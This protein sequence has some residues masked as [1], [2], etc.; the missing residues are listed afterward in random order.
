MKIAIRSGEVLHAQL[1]SRV[2][3]LAPYSDQKL[4]ESQLPRTRAPLAYFTETQIGM[5]F[6]RWRYRYLKK[7]YVLTT[8]RFSQD[9]SLIDEQ[10]PPALANL[11]NCKHLAFSTP[12]FR[13]FCSVLNVAPRGL[14]AFST[15]D[16]HIERSTFDDVDSSNLFHFR[17]LHSAD[18]PPNV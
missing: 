10:L 17:V 6:N 3:R 14:Q 18:L 13:Q 5:T 11:N 2:L 7:S 4:P 9:I 15:S 8:I 12:N 1:L 16:A